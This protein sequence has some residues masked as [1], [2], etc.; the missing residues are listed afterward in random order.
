[1]CVL[2]FQV[3]P[4]IALHVHHLVQRLGMKFL[5]KYFAVPVIDPGKNRTN[6]ACVTL[7]SVASHI[8]WTIIVDI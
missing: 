4:P 3:A 5:Q 7:Q 2:N 1:M 6:Y 8:S